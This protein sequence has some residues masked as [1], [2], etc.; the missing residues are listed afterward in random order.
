[1]TATSE[2]SPSGMVVRDQR[3]AVN[4]PAALPLAAM[5]DSAAL[6]HVITRA[7]QDPKLDL[8]RV[9]RLFEMHEK[10]QAKQAEKDFIDAM[11]RFRATVPEIRKTKRACLHPRVGGGGTGSTHASLGGVCLAIVPAL[12]AVGISNR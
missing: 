11:G 7:A 9:Q 4:E 10:L 12:A 1:M 2:V 3:S 8:D 5:T 6:M